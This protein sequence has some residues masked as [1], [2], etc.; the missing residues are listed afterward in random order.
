M[1]ER[2]GEVAH[3]R[4]RAPAFGQSAFGRVVGGVQIHIG[5]RADQAV[6]PALGRQ[7]GLFAR[8]EF[9]RAVRAKVQHRVGGVVVAQVAVKGALALLGGCLLAMRLPWQLR[10][11]AL[12]LLVPLLCWQAPR[13]APGQFELLAPDIGQGN[14]V[15]VRTATHTLL[16]DAGPR[17][18]RESDAGHRVLV[19]LLRALGERV[20][21]LM[22]SHRDADHT[23][24]AAAVLAQQPAAA[25][26]GSIEAEHVLQALRPAT[27]CVAGQRWEWDG[28]ALEVL[29]PTGAELEHRDHRDRLDR[30]VRPNT[31]SCVL[32]VASA[33]GMP[34]AQA[35]ALL[36]GD[37]EA[38][39]E[40]ALLARAAPL[41]ADVLLVPH[42]GSKTSSSGA[43][44][45][46]VQPR[47]ALV[48][49][50]YRNRFGH[51][52]YQAKIVEKEHATLV[53]AKRG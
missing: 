47:T 26:M 22:L 43:F 21:V 8:H 18:S 37:I 24:G 50:G 23:G 9:E 42:H 16:Y 30:P 52:G 12:P 14:A 15:L 29:H 3:Q 17:F 45:D 46:A 20:D 39:Q 5:Q 38:P 27:P 32:R 36:V 44:L 49:S 1:C 19:P 31:M 6:G 33:A 53:T 51:A 7:A 25:L 11:W 2:G 48:Q 40:Q 34:G 13:P 35:V 28:V 10:L 41:K 4:G